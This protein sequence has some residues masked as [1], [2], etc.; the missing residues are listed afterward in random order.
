MLDVKNGT[1]SLEKFENNFFL[2]FLFVLKIGSGL[3]KSQDQIHVALSNIY[4]RTV[5]VY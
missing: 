4:Y 1:K 2:F 3:C 5:D